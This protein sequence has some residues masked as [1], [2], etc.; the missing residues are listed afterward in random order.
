M[1]FSRCPKQIKMDHSIM[2]YIF[3]QE[4]LCKDKNFKS[5][6]CTLTKNVYS[7]KECVLLQ[8][9]CTKECV[10]SQRMCTDHKECVLSQRM[11]A[12]TKNVY[13]YKADVYSHKECVLSQRMCTLTKN[14]YYYKA[15]TYSHKKCVLS[16][17]MRLH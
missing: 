5:K 2:Y 8:R 17:R 6:M 11:C 9:M 7:H 13:S 16:Q 4:Y 14:V 3:A 1:I 10:L 12:H 15:D